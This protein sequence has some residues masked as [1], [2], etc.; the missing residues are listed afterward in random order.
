VKNRI[1]RTQRRMS[2]DQRKQA[3]LRA[4]APVIAQ[5]GL[6]G[7]SIKEIATAAGVSE[8][9]LYKHFPSKQALYDEALAAAREHSRTTISRFATL[10]PST[11]S[12]ML[13]TYATIDFIMFGFPGR[14]DHDSGPARLVMQS[15]LGDGE[16]A[17]AVFADTAANW[18]GYVTDSF[19]AAVAAGDVV[20]MAT[21]PANRF[22]F[23]QQLGM[24]LRLS[25]LPERPAFDYPGDRRSLADAATLFSLRGVGLTDAAIARYFHPRQLAKTLADLFTQPADENCPN[26]GG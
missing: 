13:L 10:T 17:R 26:A 5:N 4:A 22:R 8:A 7:S 11:Q 14:R 6:H 23:V 19:N 12:F 16:H 20:E 3:I 9:L 24:A 18:M 1:A 25:H 2:A 15:L 21:E